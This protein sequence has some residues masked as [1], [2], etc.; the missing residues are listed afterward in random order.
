MIPAADTL[1]VYQIVIH[2][3]QCPIPNDVHP[4]H[5][6]H[7]ILGF[8]LFCDAFTGR[9][10]LNQLKKH[11]FRLFAKISQIAVQPARS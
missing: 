8:E 7:L 1:C 10:L 6:K 9:H 3:F 11:R 5:P 4:L 2:D